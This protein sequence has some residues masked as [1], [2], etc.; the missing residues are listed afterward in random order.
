MTRRYRKGRNRRRRKKQH[1]IVAFG[2]RTPFTRQYI[3]KMKWAGYV[4]LD[5]PAGGISQSYYIANSVYQPGSSAAGSVQ[6]Y[7]FD[8]LAALYDHYHVLGAKMKVTVSSPLVSDLAPDNSIVALLVS[9]DSAI[10]VTA[11]TP[12][13]LLCRPGVK[14]VIYKQGDEPKTLSITYSAKKF[15]N[16]VNVT[17]NAELRG[18]SGS[19]PT[20]LAYFNLVQ[21]PMDKT[22]TNPAQIKCYIE[23]EYIVM[24]SEPKDYTASII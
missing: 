7:G 16:C 5:A 18:S 24:W 15:H 8:Q 17:D 4:S 22:A 6:C 11:N 19:N 10:N 20:E 1:R 13:S 23:T 12:N 3:T 21:L 2:T 14:K 9:D